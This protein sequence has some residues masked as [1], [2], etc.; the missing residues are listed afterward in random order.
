MKSEIKL[1]HLITPKN[2]I[3]PN[4]DCAVLTPITDNQ[5]NSQPKV[6]TEPKK[7]VGILLHLGQ[8]DDL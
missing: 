2:I 5:K 7:F 1:E 6:Q 3:T 4:P 8:R